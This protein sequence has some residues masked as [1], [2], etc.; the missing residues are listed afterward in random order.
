VQY[1]KICEE[2]MKRL[3]GLVEQILSMSMERRKTLKMNKEN[4]K[5]RPMMDRLT[6]D[7]HIKSHKEIRFSID[8]Q[9]DDMTV[10]A[11]PVHFFN[12]VSNIIDNSV[13]YSGDAVAVRIHAYRDADRDYIVLTDDGIGISDENQPHVFDKFYR[14]GHGNQYNVSGYGLGLYYV[15]Q[16]IERHGGSISVESVVNEGTTFT[17]TLPVK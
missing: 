17:I 7:F 5:L 16:I 4:V 15:Q 13:K 2:Q 3:S 9:P 10:Y 12:A 11:D 8:I 6:D 14:V 1:L